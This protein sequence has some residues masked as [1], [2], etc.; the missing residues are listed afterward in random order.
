LIVDDDPDVL[1]AAQVVL[2][3][4]FRTVVTDNDPTHLPKLLADG[5]FD[6]VLLDMNFA[7]GVTSGEEGIGWLKTVQ[8]VSPDTKVILM[9]AY[10]AVDMAVNAMKQGASDFVVKPWDNDRL[11]ATVRSTTRLSQAARAIRNLES[12]QKVLNRDTGR[13]RGAIIGQSAAIRGVL[14]TIQ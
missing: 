1:L 14:A 4:Q 11:V 12:V 8:R 2:K 9:T 6:V 13:T 5:N 7:V 3:K 10:G